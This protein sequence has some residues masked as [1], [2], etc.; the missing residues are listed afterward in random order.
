MPAED[1]RVCPKCS[2]VYIEDATDADFDATPRNVCSPLSQPPCPAWK[3]I[4]KATQPHPLTGARTMLTV[5]S[6]G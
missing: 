1:K 5:V 4:G 3:V 2:R 6:D